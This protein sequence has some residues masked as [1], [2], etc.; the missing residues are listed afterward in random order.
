MN[1]GSKTMIWMAVLCVVGLLSLPAVP[2]QTGGSR[3]SNSGLEKLI[4][5]A[6][7]LTNDLD[8]DFSNSL[9]KTRPDGT[10]EEDRLQNQ[11]EA[12]EDTMDEIHSGY[13]KTPVRTRSHTRCI[14]LWP[15]PLIS[16]ASS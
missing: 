5:R 15:S 14:A 6:E 16:I 4:D 3:L 10:N 12:L 7:N 1:A 13:K 11:A 2:A 9:D 8:D